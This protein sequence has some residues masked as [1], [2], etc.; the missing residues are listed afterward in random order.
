MLTAQVIGVGA[1]GNKGAFALVK[2]GV[3]RIQDTL[4]VNSTLKDIP[5][6][7]ENNKELVVQIG[8]KVFDGC[9]KERSEGERLAVEAIQAGRLHLDSWLNP[10]TTMVIIIT[11]TEGGTGSGAS[12][13][14]AKYLRDVMHVDVK[15]YAFT[16]FEE[17]SRGLRNT[18]EFFKRMQD[19]YSIHVI[20]NKKFISE[21]GGN[22]TKAEALANKELS[23]QISLILGHSIIDSDTNMD[24]TDLRKVTTN[25]GYTEVLYREVSDKIKNVEEFNKIIRNMIDNSKGMDVNDPSQ[26]LMGVI[27][28]IPESERDAIDYTWTEVIN[29]Y[30]E[31]FERFRHIQYDE[32]SKRSIT[33]IASGIKIPIEEIQAVWDRYKERNERVNKQR[34]DLASAFEGLDMEDDSMFDLRNKNAGSN[35]KPSEKELSAFFGAFG[36][37]TPNV[38]K[39]SSSNKTVKSS[40]KDLDKF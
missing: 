40:E 3:V 34:E 24:D 6:E 26:T 38:P 23:T 35:A 21:A 1:A 36:A 25:T 29:R 12:V 8:N 10:E 19:N 11:S 2:D 15:I 37:E 28:N 17:D 22:F 16:G 5:K 20:R 18:V 32:E 4:L 30:G 39:N 13:V 31:P 33:I 27:L 14:M 7:Y 9:G